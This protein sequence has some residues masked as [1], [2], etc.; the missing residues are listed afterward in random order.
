MVKIDSSE[1]YNKWPNEI[2]RGRK[3]NWEINSKPYFYKRPGSNTMIII[4]QNEGII[5]K[6][7]IID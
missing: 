6:R 7:I 3:Q 4:Y 5:F 1:N 2:I